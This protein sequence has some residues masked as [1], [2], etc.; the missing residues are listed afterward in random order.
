MSK[1][2]IAILGD[3]GWGTTL[4]LLLHKK[5]FKVSL[6]SAFCDYARYLDRARINKKFLPGIKIPRGIRITDDLGAALFGKDLIVLAVPAQH[7][8]AVL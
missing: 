2:D 4:A 1:P 8:R 6:W 3:G 5:K 7:I